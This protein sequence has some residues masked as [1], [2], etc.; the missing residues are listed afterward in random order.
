MQCDSVT[1]IKVTLGLLPF[2]QGLQPTFAT[3]FRYYQECIKCANNCLQHI[4]TLEALKYFVTLRICS[5]SLLVLTV[6]T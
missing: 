1:K 3:F 2:A 4:L 5:Y 6:L